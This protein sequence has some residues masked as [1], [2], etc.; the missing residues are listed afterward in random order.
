MTDSQMPPVE[1]TPVP[2]PPSVTPSSAVPMSSVQAPKSYF[3]KLYG[4][5][6]NRM[7]YFLAPLIFE[8]FVFLVAFAIGFAYGMATGDRQ[9]SALSGAVS[10]VAFIFGL[11]YGWSFAV[12]RAHDIGKKWTYLLWLF[13]PLVNIVIGFIL[14]FRKGD[15]QDNQYGPVTKPGVHIGEL[16]GLD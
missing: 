5:R 15:Q 13:I 6:L 3:Q 4:G 11:L 10:T 8:V 1:L 9:A 14:L 16:F 2:P 7:S 12:R